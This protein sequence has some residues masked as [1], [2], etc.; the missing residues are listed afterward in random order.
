MKSLI[1]SQISKIRPYLPH[2]LDSHHHTI[3][4]SHTG[5]ERTHECIRL[6]GCR[7]KWGKY[8]ACSSCH[9]FFW[10]WI[11]FK[12]FFL[13]SAI[14]SNVNFCGVCAFIIYLFESVKNKL[15]RKFTIGEMMSCLRK[16]ITRAMRTT[17]MPAMMAK[18]DI[19]PPTKG[20]NI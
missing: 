9:G 15:A 7:S 19:R 11:S 4:Y 8:F 5:I 1:L 6:V 16:I 13:R 20:S 2:N 12:S 14:S 3:E 18:L 17:L 10:A